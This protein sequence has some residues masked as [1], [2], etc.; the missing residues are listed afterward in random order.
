MVFAV[1]PVAYIALMF[2]YNLLHIE[3]DEHKR[4][5]RCPIL[6]NT[7]SSYESFLALGCPKQQF[8]P[9]SAQRNIVVVVCLIRLKENII[10]VL[11]D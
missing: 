2:R 1:V 9:F 6:A 5:S 10:S 4:L 11:S 8:C 7:V 3:L